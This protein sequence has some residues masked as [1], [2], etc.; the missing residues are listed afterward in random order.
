MITANQNPDQTAPGKIDNM[1]FATGFCTY[2]T[3]FSPA[4]ITLDV[5]KKLPVAISFK[6]V[7]R[8]IVSSRPPFIIL[9]ATEYRY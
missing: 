2:K 4:D 7:I 9:S 8:T 3:H 1:L 5:S 6:S